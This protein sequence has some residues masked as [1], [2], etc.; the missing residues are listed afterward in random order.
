MTILGAEQKISYAEFLDLLETIEKPPQIL[1]IAPGRLLVKYRD[2]WRAYL[3]N[4][5]ISASSTGDLVVGVV[6]AG[7][8]RAVVRSSTPGVFDQGLVIRIVPGSS[9]TLGGGS[10]ANSG[11]TSCANGVATQITTA[12]GAVIPNMIVKN[13]DPV[14]AVELGGSGLTIGG[15]YVLEAL[16]TSDD[17]VWMR[18][19]NPTLLYGAGIGGAVTVCW[20]G[21]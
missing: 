19:V 8:T 6:G 5:M 15:G 16:G 17:S 20:L 3:I 9:V 13:L 21:W 18:N 7:G 4:D 1:Q 14:N 12:F 2:Q 10:S 11:R